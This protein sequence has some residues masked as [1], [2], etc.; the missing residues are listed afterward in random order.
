MKLSIIIPCFN[1]KKTIA[2][3]LRQIDETDLG[4]AEKEIIVVDDGS[5]N[6]SRQVL[7]NLKK[8]YK[9]ILLSHK[10]N[11]GKGAALKTGCQ[12]ALKLGTDV[13]VAIDADGQHSPSDIPK[14]VEKLQ[15]E[16]LDIIFGVREVNKKMPFLFRLGNK[17]LTKAINF[18]SNVSLS[19]TQTGFKAFTSRIYPKIAWQ[20]SDYSVETEIIFN[21]GKNKLK[22]GQVPIR[23]VYKDIYKG[24][25]IIDGLKIFFNLLK[26]KFL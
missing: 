19:D 20:S 5:T 1:E 8:K 24:T 2:D 7:E 26:Q 3:I 16:K 25:T 9:F 17:F 11:L 14:L 4:L 15:K 13:I 23:S 10:M 6:I 12:A 21:V 18:L 22:Y